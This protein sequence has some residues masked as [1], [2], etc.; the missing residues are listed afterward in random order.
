MARSSRSFALATQA[1]IDEASAE[2]PPIEYEF[3]DPD[4]TPVPPKKTVPPR[5]CV[6]HHP[7]EG[8]MFSMAASVGMSEAQLL[9]P[10]GELVKF[11]SATFKENG[12]FA[13]IWDQVG[14]SRLDIREDIM[15]LVADLM[16]EWSGVPTKQ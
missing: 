12:D 16:E 1:S 2:Y 3:T 8:R 5:V 14:K 11:L 6:A 10:A 13:F 4:A 9:N 7:G 15:A